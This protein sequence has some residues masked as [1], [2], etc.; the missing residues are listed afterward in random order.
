MSVSLGLSDQPHIDPA[1]LSS[2][3][4][5]ER[6]GQ[7]VFMAMPYADEVLVEA[8]G[9][10]IRDADGREMLDLAAG[11]FCSV[12]GHNHPGFMRRILGQAEK[13]L[14]TGTQFISPPVFEAAAKLAEIAP[15]RLRKSIFLSTGTEAN[16]FAFRIAKAW[17]GRT[18]IAGLSRGYYGTSL[19][20]RS[21]SALFSHRL[22][23][24]LPVVPDS[25]RI[26]IA[27]GCQ[28][29]FTGERTACGFP[30]LEAFEAQMGDWSNVAAIIAE[31]VLSAGGMLFPPPGYFQRLRELATR[32]GALLIV[33]E[34]QTGFGRTGKWF[35]IEHHGVEPDILTL[36]KS[37]GNGFAV[38]AVITTPEIADKVV[39]NGLWNLSSHQS[40]PVAAAAVA[41][42]IDCVREENLLERAGATGEYF[43]GR[44][45]DLAT[46]QPAVRRVRG[47]GLMIGFDCVPAECPERAAEAANAFMYACRRRG[48]HVT[49]GYGGYN[50]RII[51]PLVLSREQVD[52]AVETMEKA[53][54]EILADPAKW[55]H[56]V[57][58]NPYT[59]SAY[60]Q[61][62]WKR[63]LTQWWRSTPEEWMSKGVRLLRGGRT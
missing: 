23:D 21:C 7:Y 55:K 17:T 4:Y 62:P 3:D 58:N 31:P 61:S 32:H 45:R 46:R 1:Q 20:T 36:S 47:I 6:Y 41:A 27:G 48:L 25:V 53:L 5:W 29:C 43:L 57:A 30:C 18:A 8:R 11:M 40:D 60:G 10:V 52:F 15:G 50:I 33:D 37:I 49:Y 2:S 51:P 35:A 14:H 42:V 38:A 24:T 28:D 39:A 13:L 59:A 44:L 9:C 19:A 22:K 26:P 12:L 56:A 16:E 54:D 34:A 63:V